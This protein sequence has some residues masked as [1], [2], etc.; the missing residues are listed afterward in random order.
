MYNLFETN[1]LSNIKCEIFEGSK[2][3]T[4]DNFYRY[5]DEILEFL[6]IRSTPNLWKAEEQPSY[7][8]K[9]FLDKR[10]NFYVPGFEAIEAALGNIC[11]QT[12]R[13]PGRVVTN[14]T[15]FIDK[16]F[17]N[18]KN[19]YWAPHTDL[20]YNAII[21][22][23]SSGTNIY[24]QIEDDFETMP[25]HYAPWRA[26]SKFQ[27]LKTLDAEYNRLVMFDGYR[28][29]HGMDIAD[30][31]YFKRQRVNQAIFFN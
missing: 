5:P 25:E 20:G 26:K 17:N 30:D 24:D 2:I 11:G 19:N 29:L 31:T 3:F 8:G 13:Y 18:Y 23:T 21:Y 15:Q 28:F 12:V 4:M 6:L 1:D 14:C 7:N 16:S 10:H 22:F 9:Y 27:L